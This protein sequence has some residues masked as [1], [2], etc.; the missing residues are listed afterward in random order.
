LPLQIGR[1][2]PFAEPA[3]DRGQQIAPHHLGAVRYY[4]KIGVELAANLLSAR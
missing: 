4:R 2:K 1:A 3:I